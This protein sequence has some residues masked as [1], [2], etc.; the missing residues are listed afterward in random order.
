M[1]TKNRGTAVRVGCPFKPLAQVLHRYIDAGT[2][3]YVADPSPNIFV[4]VLW[5]VWWIP[6]FPGRQQGDIGR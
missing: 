6:R 1:Y 3:R 5:E 4:H 2:D